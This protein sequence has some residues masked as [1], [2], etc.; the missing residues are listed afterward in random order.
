VYATT[1]YIITLLNWCVN[2]GV[3]RYYLYL[4]AV[5]TSPPVPLFIIF[6]LSPCPLPLPREGGEKK[7]GASAPLRRLLLFL[8]AHPELV[9]GLSFVRR[10]KREN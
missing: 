5:L 7:R 8:S 9:E 1:A 3:F 4:V 2:W 6:D 10:D